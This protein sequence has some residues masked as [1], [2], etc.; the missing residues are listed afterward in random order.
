MLG[1]VSRM[2]V[3]SMT[4]PS[5]SGTLKSTRMKMRWS[6]RERSRIESLDMRAPIRRS[7]LAV[8]CSQPAPHQQKSWQR[9]ESQIANDKQ[10]M[11]RVLQS[12]GRHQI[13][14]VADTAGVSPLVVIPGDQFHAVAADYKGHGRVDDRGPGVALEIGGDQF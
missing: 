6:L 11:A 14:Q 3:S 8:R 2:R 10:R 13:Y 12:L 9:S 1:K 4:R 7:L 5:S